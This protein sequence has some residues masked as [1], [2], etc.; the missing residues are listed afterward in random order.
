MSICHGFVFLMLRRPPRSTR[1][2]TLFPYTTLFR[3]K[4]MPRSGSR[5]AVGRAGRR[6]RQRQPRGAGQLVAV[7]FAHPGVAAPFLDQHRGADAGRPIDG[8]GPAVLADL[9]GDEDAA[10]QTRR[11]VRTG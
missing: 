11:E 8:P 3:S 4:A 2:D 5:R 6:A 9:A 1:T 7:V 10:A